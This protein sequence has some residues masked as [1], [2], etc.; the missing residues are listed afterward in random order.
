VT[1]GDAEGEAPLA[2][3]LA[4]LVLHSDDLTW[5]LEEQGL[6]FDDGYPYGM[7]WSTSHTSIEEAVAAETY[8]MAR[9]GFTLSRMGEDEAAD[10]LEETGWLRAH[11]QQLA[12]PDPEA[13]DSWSLAVAVTIEE[14]ATADGAG[15]ALRAFDDEEVLQDIAVTPTVERLDLPAAFDGM[16]AAMWTLETTR[17][18][19][20]YGVTEIAS[21]W[22]QVDRFVVSVALVHGPGFVAPDP[23]LLVPLME[24]QLKRLEHA[25]HLYQPRLALCAPQFAGEQVADWRADYTV[26][27][28][29]AFPSVTST[30]DD[31]AEA[32]A[33]ADDLGIVDNF[34]VS[35]SIDETATGAYDGMLWFQGRTRAFADEDLAAEFLAATGSMLEEDGYTEIEDLDDVP[36]LGDGTAAYGYT[37]NDGHAATIVY[38]QVG[39]QVVSLRLGSTTEPVPEAAFDLAAQHLEGMT[40]GPCDDLNVPRGL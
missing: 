19:D 32:Q 30:F 5:L 12:L 18:S 26:L 24:L 39:E 6:L 1:A 22:V 27:N 37:G 17:Y 38:I 11:D 13:E 35:Q 40:D 20:D 25:E 23:D 15:Q 9:G 33:E 10:F 21:L 3:D 28:G 34:V 31:L 36:D 4:A 14:F 8:A 29:Q 16:D 2:L 7:L